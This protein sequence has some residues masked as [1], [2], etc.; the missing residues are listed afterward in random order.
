[1]MLLAIEGP[2]PG[3][4]ASCSAVAELMLIFA[5]AAA[6]WPVDAGAFWA[7]TETEP[8]TMPSESA[9]MQAMPVR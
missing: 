3:R 9:N 1:M 6:V 2:M 5:A 4:D 7:R 8:K